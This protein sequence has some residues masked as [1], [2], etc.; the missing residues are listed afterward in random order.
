MFTAIQSAL[1]T[2][3]ANNDDIKQHNA[4]QALVEIF[5][6]IKKAEL[7]EDELL[8]DFALLSFYLLL[9]YLYATAVA[10]EYLRKAKTGSCSLQFIRFNH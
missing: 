6:S 10:K 1:I 5:E 3:Q 7:Q 8:K 2:L 9:E 4:Y